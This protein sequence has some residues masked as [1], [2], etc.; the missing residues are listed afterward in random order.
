M[1]E[2]ALE[3]VA[4]LNPSTSQKNVPGSSVFSSRRMRFWP[5]ASSAGVLS[6]LLREQGVGIG[7][8]SE[9]IAL[10]I[11]PQTI[12]FLW[13]PITDFW[14]RRRTWLIVGALG[15]RPHSGRRLPRQQARHS[16][17]VALMFLSACFGQ[18]DRLQLRRNDGHAPQRSHSPQSQQLLSGRLARLRSSRH[19]RPRLASPKKS[20]SAL[21]AG[22]PQPSSPSHPSPPSPPRSSHEHRT[23]ADASDKLSPASGS[24]FKDDLLLLASRPLHPRSCSFPCAAEPP[25]ASSPASRRTTTSAA[26]RWHG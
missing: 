18:L 8:S 15:C 26:S 25:S 14:I 19:L 7:R 5:T 6:Y 12:Y 22:L 21:S 4:G 10:L 24:E 23:G 2:V 13:S 1:T 9:I 16:S 3:Q 20:P 17:A 11:L